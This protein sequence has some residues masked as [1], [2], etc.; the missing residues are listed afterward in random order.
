[1][2]ILLIDRENGEWPSKSS[3]EILPQLAHEYQWGEVTF[4]QRG[5]PILQ[6]GFCSVSHSRN[7]MIIAVADYPIGIDIEYKRELRMDL[8]KRLRLNPKTPLEDWCLREAWIKLDDDPSHLMKTL[9]PSLFTQTLDL[10][11]AWLCKLVSR[12]EFGPITLKKHIL[13][14]ES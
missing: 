8:M 14:K 6:N 13:Q 11:E 4:S 12:T 9:P 7:R 1:M 10:G 3:R 2:L 5:K